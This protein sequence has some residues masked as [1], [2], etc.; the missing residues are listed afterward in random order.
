[1][2]K[3][4][5]MIE[6]VPRIDFKYSGQTMPKKD[7]PLFLKD[8]MNHINEQCK[9]KLNSC[10][11]NYYPDGTSNI[12]HHSD[13]KGYKMGSNNAVVTISLG[14]SRTFQFKSKSS[15]FSIDTILD[16]GDMVMMYGSCQQLYTHSILKEK[17]D[18]PRVS[19]TFR[20]LL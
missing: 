20:E 19:L 2:L 12:G 13:G 16:N 3:L 11:I 15:D 18:I 5:S 1:M 14:G 17:T 6:N 4:R 10:L 9:L 8:V 7:M